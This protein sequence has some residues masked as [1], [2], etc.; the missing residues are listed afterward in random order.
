MIY[1]FEKPNTEAWVEY[2][3]FQDGKF[4]GRGVGQ[5][6]YGSEW[7]LCKNQDMEVIRRENAGYGWIE[8]HGSNNKTIVKFNVSC[9][10]E[11]IDYTGFIEQFTYCKKCDVKK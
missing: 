2:S 5:Q 7:S 8:V 4:Y 1:R 6:T 9:D 10:H 11:F 3:K